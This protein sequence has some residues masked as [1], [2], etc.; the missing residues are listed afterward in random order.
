MEQNRFL[1][2]STI[3]AFFVTLFTFFR[4]ATVKISTG[5]PRLISH[6]ARGIP[7]VILGPDLMEGFRPTSEGSELDADMFSFILR[8][9]RELEEKVNALQTN[10]MQLPSEKEELLKGA[11]RRVD[12]LE[13]ELITTKKVPFPPVAAW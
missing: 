6:C 8:R 12:G 3:M 2:L 5:I 7:N 13:A 10:P 11:I 9:L 1:F 4:S